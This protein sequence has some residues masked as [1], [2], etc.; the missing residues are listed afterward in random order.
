[1]Y[2]LPEQVSTKILAFQLG[3]ATIRLTAGVAGF[4]FA[5]AAL[6]VLVAL[7]GRIYCSTI[8]PL[9]FLQDLASWL[10]KILRINHDWEISYKKQLKII[11]AGILGITLVLLAAG[12]AFAAGLLE[13]FAVF[14]RMMFIMK[15]PFEGSV[16]GSLTAILFIIVSS[17]IILAIAVKK[18][19]FFCSW[20]CPVGTM[21]WGLSVIS[22][23][24]F[25]I[26][27]T[28]CN[29][30]QRC[31]VECKSSAISVKEKRIDQA[32]CVG[33]FNCVPVC[34]SGAIKVAPDIFNSKNK[35]GIIEADS[36]IN[37]GRRK[38]LRQFGTVMLV[39][40]SPSGT[41]F[42]SIFI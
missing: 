24:K 13:P 30:C 35:A 21:L 7:F 31:L 18:G 5:V 40:G 25:R 27:Q 8:C 39:I 6:L 38:F 14:S 41:R 2:I 23:F 26:K 16:I 22:L 29:Q 3:P 10:G 32:L 28:A 12:S 20:L 42:P 33:C 15:M 11:R 1:L 17:F 36:E 37:S 9:G 4:S 19:R 34:K